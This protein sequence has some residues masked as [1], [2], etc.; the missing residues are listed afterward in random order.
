MTTTTN[1]KPQR[2][3]FGALINLPDEQAQNAKVLLR[4]AIASGKLEEEYSTVEW[5]ARRGCGIGWALNYAIYDVTPSA[6]LVQRRET[7]CHKYGITPHKDY[8]IIR[9]CG[10]G[11]R[12]TEASKAR[13]VKLANV[14]TAFGQVID[15]L[16]GRAKKPLKQASPFSEKELAYKLV[17]VR[18]DGYYSVF[19]EDFAWPLGKARIEAASGDHSGGFYVFP[20]IATAKDAL[21]RNV[22]FNDAWVEGKTLALVECE[23]AG[24]GFRHDNGKI[25]VTFCRPTRVLETFTDPEGQRVAA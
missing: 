3:K 8:F 2:D 21:E 6:V 4:Q 24:R 11:V 18:D 15:T 13:V 16:E 12:V 7:E 23:I 20:T 17:E 9:R 19:D 10:A 22:V 14:S 25:C 1:N 5:N